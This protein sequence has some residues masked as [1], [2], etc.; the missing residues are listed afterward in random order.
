MSTLTT[1]YIFLCPARKAARAVVASGQPAWLYRYDHVASFNAHIWGPMYPY[2][3]KDVVCHGSE[4]I[5]LFDTASAGGLTMTPPESAMSKSLGTMWA[6]MAKSPAT[7][8]SPQGSGLPN[9]PNY[10]PTTDTNLVIDI[11]FTTQAAL[12]SEFCDTFDKIG[13]KY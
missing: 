10:D 6:N 13:Y 7:G 4:L 2:C 3:A 8:P 11:P 9:W 12:R 5:F 1:D